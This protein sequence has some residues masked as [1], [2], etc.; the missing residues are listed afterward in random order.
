M[1]GDPDREY[2]SDG[3]ADDIITDV[4]RIRWLFV[5]ARISQRFF[6][7]TPLLIHQMVVTLEQA[8]L[9][10]RPQSRGAS[11]SWLGTSTGHNHCAEVLIQKLIR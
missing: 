8:G 1:N 7:V 9:I 6:R 3:I 5:I 2:F 11:L 4:S 10:S